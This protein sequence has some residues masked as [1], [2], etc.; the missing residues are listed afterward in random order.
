MAF[1]FGDSQLTE[2]KQIRWDG[3][4]FWALLV[5]LVWVPI[6]LGSNRAWP[7]TVLEVYAFALL[8]LWLLL[9]AF[10]RVEV[11]ESMK[12]AVPAWI[13]LALWLALQALH[14]VPMPA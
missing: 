2:I 6:P 3:I 1:S 10:G 5:L 9:W 7:W 11:S 4:L 14:I 13:V 8:P 12:G